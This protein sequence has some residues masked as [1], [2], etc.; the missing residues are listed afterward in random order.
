MSDA[1]CYQAASMADQ[2]K[3]KAVVTLTYSGYTA[4]QISALRPNCH[5]Q[6][7]SPNKRVLAML[8]LYWGVKAKYYE[9]DASTTKT[10]SQVNQMVVDNGVLQSGDYVINLNSTPV[11][12]K[13]MVNNLRVTKIE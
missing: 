10:I 13:G 8:N 1:V 5:V 7:F 4:F 12:K 11:K 6:V 2:I 9:S 3:A